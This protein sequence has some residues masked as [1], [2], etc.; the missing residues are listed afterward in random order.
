MD[1]GDPREHPQLPPPGYAQ[2][3][4][5]KAVRMPSPDPH[6]AAVISRTS[7]VRLGRLLFGPQWTPEQPPGAPRPA[8]DILADAGGAGAL[9]AVAYRLSATG[10]QMAAAAPWVV[11]RAEAGLVTDSIGHRPPG[12][13][14]SR[15]FYPAHP[16]QIESLTGAY[17]TVMGAEQKSAAAL[18][19]AAHSAGTPVP[20]AALD[21]AAHRAI[22]QEQQWITAQ[23]VRTPAR[24][25]PRAHVPTDLVLGR[26]PGLR[27]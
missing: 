20:R 26:S 10:W 6:P 7:V 27:Q 3:L 15:R 12:L 16:R 19:T 9:A 11:R 25:L 1:T 18:L 22:A 24:A 21:A 23:P 13:D 5:G 14:Q 2:V 8:A 17:S 4:Q